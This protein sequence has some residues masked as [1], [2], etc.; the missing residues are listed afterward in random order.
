MVDMTLN[1]AAASVKETVQE[2]AADSGVFREF[3]KLREDLAH[4]RDALATTGADMLAESKAAAGNRLAE[5]QDEVEKLASQVRGQGG[6]MLQ[7][8]DTK[9][10][11]RPL[12]SIAVAFGIGLLA[13]QLLRR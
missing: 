4:L 9:V 6:E 12:T 8:I 3:A 11:E 10:Q 2:S 1:E 5:L 7:R 13:A